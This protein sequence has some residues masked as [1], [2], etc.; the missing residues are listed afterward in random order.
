MPGFIHYGVDQRITQPLHFT[1]EYPKFDTTGP[2][3]LPPKKLTR[4]RKVLDGI[5]APAEK[6]LQFFPVIRGTLNNHP[7]QLCP[8][9]FFLPSP[10]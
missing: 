6:V 2:K 1:V 9:F 3:T 10:Q 7:G 8:L 4:L 5:S